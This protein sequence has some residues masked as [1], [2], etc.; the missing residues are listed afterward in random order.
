MQS[1]LQAR[2]SENNVDAPKAD[3]DEVPR[4]GI[5]YFFMTEQG[6]FRKRRDLVDLGCPLTEDGG[7]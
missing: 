2:R 4:V 7:E 1:A 5:D 3:N 6:E